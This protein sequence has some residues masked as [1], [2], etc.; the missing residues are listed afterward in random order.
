MAVA[1][2]RTIEDGQEGA[3]RALREDTGPR[4]VS[5]LREMFREASEHHANARILAFRDERFYHNFNNDQWT[6]EEQ[7]ELI[8]RNQPIVTSNWIKRRVNF[9]VG[10]EQ[11]SRTDPVVYPRNPGDEMSAQVARQVLVFLDDQTDL[12]E[13]LSECFRELA[14]MGIEAVEVAVD[15]EQ[16]PNPN[17]PVVVNKIDYRSFFFDPRSRRSNFSDA[18]YLGYQRWYDM[19]EA[20]AIFG[21]ENRDIIEGSLSFGPDSGDAYDEGYE[22]KPRY[23]GHR[24]RRRVRIAVCYY[25]LGANDWYYAYYTGAGVLRGG[26]SPYFENGRPA[27]P[28]KA[29]S[30]FV[31]QEN[32]RYGTIRDMISLQREINMR[33]TLALSLM[34]NRRMWAS[35]KGVFPSPAEAKKTV[36]QSDAILIANGQFGEEW[37]F[38]ESN[39]EYAANIQLLQEAK[40]ELQLQ[41]AN[42]ALQGREVASQSGRAI[43]AQQ[44]SGITEENPLFD[45][46]NQFK[47]RIYAAMWWRAKQFMTAP[48]WVRITENEQAPQFVGINVPGAYDPYTGQAAPSQNV[49]S[50]MEVDISIRTTPDLISLQHETFERLAELV[51][52]GQPIP[53]LAL[54]EMMP[55]FHNKQKIVELVQRAQEAAAQAQEAQQQ[56]AIDKEQANIRRADAEAAKNNALAT[57]ESMKAETEGAKRVN[58]NASTAELLTRPD[59]QRSP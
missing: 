7:Q 20:V 59:T 29:Q 54:I 43:R 1:N 55:A 32:E 36:A 33:R 11:R 37:G 14:C 42:S 27:C 28:I 57:L 45:A 39:T 17:Y 16:S 6:S 9:L 41:Q 34:K 22:D 51:Q 52:S 23:W 15:T 48:Q 31:T 44:D 5:Q 3:I 58:V 35:H 18:R 10:F 12:D 56:I 4:D 8:D 46:H 38:I 26:A 19:D 40:E 25:R 30:L 53:L 47:E 2:D 24:S 13:T 21:A 49:I 50:E